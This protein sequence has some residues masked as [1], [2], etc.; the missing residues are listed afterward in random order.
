MQNGGSMPPFFQC[1]Q[2]LRL[3]NSAPRPSRTRRAIRRSVLHLASSAR[4]RRKSNERGG[5][6]VPDLFHVV[7]SLVAMKRCFGFQRR[8]YDLVSA[9][10]KPTEHLAR[11]IN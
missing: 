11:F 2:G 7:A 6:F 9:H 1:Y 8:R 4:L 10:R 5:K 3:L